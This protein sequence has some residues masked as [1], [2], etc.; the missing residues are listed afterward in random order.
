M[1]PTAPTRPPHAAPEPPVYDN[2]PRLLQRALVRALD[3][4]HL[5]MYALFCLSE[6]TKK[7][8]TCDAC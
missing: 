6:K 2:N 1:T 5:E 8:G 4:D 3:G 7:R